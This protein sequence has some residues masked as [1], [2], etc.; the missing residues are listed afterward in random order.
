MSEVVLDILVVLLL[1][2]VGIFVWL[3]LSPFETLGWWAGWFG[4]RIYWESP[5]DPVAGDGA[6]RHKAYVVF[7]SGI[8]R[9]TGEALSYRERDFLQR[10][11]AANPDS[12]VID[13]IFPYAVNNLSLTAQVLMHRLWRLSLTS[14]RLG[15]P[16]FGMLI[17]VRN[18]MQILA[19][20]DRRYG[21]IFNQ[22]VAEVTLAGLMRHGFSPERSAP[23]YLIGYSGAG[24]IAVGAAAYLREWSGAPVYVISLAGVFGSDP[25]LLTIDHLYHLVGT[26]DVVEPWWVMAPGRWRFFATS[27]WNRAMRQGRVTRINMGP[28]KHTGGG[29][30]LDAKSRLPD[31]TTYIDH[32]VQVVTEIIDVGQAR[33]E[34]TL[35]EAEQRRL[36]AGDT[37]AGPTQV[38]GAGAES[39]AATE[40]AMGASPST[41]ERA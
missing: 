37:Q 41:R 22:G 2:V 20:A 31:G 33:W 26:K 32:T 5:P 19:S 34:R 16:L 11:S 6:E 17:N 38:D 40:P 12:Q 35:R 10:L 36:E 1:L 30:Y 28:M 8:G 29:G 21:P 3:A 14:K 9:A 23:I 18:I 7:F 27:E 25:S 15:V 4:D 13:D 39:Q 24:Q